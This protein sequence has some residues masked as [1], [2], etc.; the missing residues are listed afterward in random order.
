MALRASDNVEGNWLRRGEV[1]DGKRG[2][3]TFKPITVPSKGRG[4]RSED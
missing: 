4:R 1:E 3:D 2:R